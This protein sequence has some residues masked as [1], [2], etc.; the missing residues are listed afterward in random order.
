M[1]NVKTS[2]KGGSDFTISLPGGWLAPL[3]PLSV[4]SLDLCK[5]KLENDFQ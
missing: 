5:R 3:P 4:T 1:L 2:A